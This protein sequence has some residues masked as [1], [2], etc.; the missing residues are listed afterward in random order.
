[1]RG[2]WPFDLLQADEEVMAGALEGAAQPLV[3]GRAQHQLDAA[4]AHRPLQRQLQRQCVG[5]D[6]LLALLARH[7]HLLQPAL[8]GSPACP[9]TLPTH[10]NNVQEQYQVAWYWSVDRQAPAAWLA[11]GSETQ[12]GGGFSH[13]PLRPTPAMPQ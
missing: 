13:P 11:S 8:R 7:S 12:P 2:R 6:A 4:L 9:A 1:M 5:H 3:V 10:H